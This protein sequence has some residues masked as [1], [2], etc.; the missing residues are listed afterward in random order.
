MIS[1]VWI[2]YRNLKLIVFLLFIDINMVV[3]DDKVV[4]IDGNEDFKNSRV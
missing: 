4:F 2:N 1:F 3:Y